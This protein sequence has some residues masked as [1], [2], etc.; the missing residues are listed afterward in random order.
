[1]ELVG[2]GFLI[3][4]ITAIIFVGIG[5]VIGRTDSGTDKRELDGDSDTRVY[6]PC[7][8]RDGSG[9]NGHAQQHEGRRR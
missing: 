4:I 7:R 5:V 3:G 8:D 9:D 6:V 1:M 2:I